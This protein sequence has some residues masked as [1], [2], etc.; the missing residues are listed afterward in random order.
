[1]SG[2]TLWFERRPG[3]VCTDADTEL[4]PAILFGGVLAMDWFRVPPQAQHAAAGKECRVTDRFYGP[5]PRTGQGTVPHLWARGEN[6]GVAELG[7]EF[8]FYSIDSWPEGWP[9]STERAVGGVAGIF[10]L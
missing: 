7:G 2:D 9:R 10:G 1:M 5:D 6:I 8:Q 4:G 3:A